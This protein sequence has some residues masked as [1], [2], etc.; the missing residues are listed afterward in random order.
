MMIVVSFDVPKLKEIP[1]QEGFGVPS[2]EEM[3][4][5]VIAS[6]LSDMDLTTTTPFKFSEPEVESSPKVENQIEQEKA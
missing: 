2:A 4:I 1:I 6:Y 3:P 5:M